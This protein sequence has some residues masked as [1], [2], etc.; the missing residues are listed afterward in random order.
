MN[1]RH[2]K[3]AMLASGLA[4]YWPL[5]EEHGRHGYAI[6]VY[7]SPEE[8]R[9]NW[10]P[11]S[12]FGTGVV[13]LGQMLHPETKWVALPKP[14]SVE[15]AGDKIV[16]RYD[17][18][19]HDR[20]YSAQEEFRLNDIPRS[21]SRIGGLPDVHPN[22]E[23]P[24]SNGDYFDFVAQFFLEELP[25]DADKGVLPIQGTLSLYLYR[26]PAESSENAG[27]LAH[28]DFQCNVHELIPIGT[29]PRA[30]DWRSRSTLFPGGSVVGDDNLNGLTQSSYHH[31]LDFYSHFYLPCECDG[32][33][34]QRP[35]WDEFGEE[36][37]AKYIAFEM[38]RRNLDTE[39]GSIHGECGASQ[40]S[41]LLGHFDTSQTWLRN[42]PPLRS[43]KNPVL[44]F[45]LMSPVGP[46]RREFY[47][48]IEQDDLASSNFSD[49]KVVL[50]L[51]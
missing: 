21:R 33:D 45:Q 49:I 42:D 48:F 4:E 15:R 43:M 8:R 29:H 27:W 24:T 28:V 25:G 40:M 22:F 18:D 5:V 14:M 12:A 36:S 10:S 44:L 1:A 32:I 51:D 31:S 11:P 13:H 23:W 20:F 35:F 19:A 2:L 26:D 41:R 39:F 16:V 50:D 37:S 17:K 6:K 9:A 3:S 47:F 7:D 38:I 46:F 30:R 34:G